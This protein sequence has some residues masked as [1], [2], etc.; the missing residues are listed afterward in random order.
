[1]ERTWRPEVADEL[2]QREENANAERSFVSIEQ[3]GVSST[4]VKRQM[5]E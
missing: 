1:M 2:E 3:A 4:D 5:P